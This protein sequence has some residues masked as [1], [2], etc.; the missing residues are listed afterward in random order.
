VKED[1]YS[2]KIHRANYY[3]STFL[4]EISRPISRLPSIFSF[5]LSIKRNHRSADINDQSNTPLHFTSLS[6]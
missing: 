3:D 4:I 6:G 2:N 1:S 5:D